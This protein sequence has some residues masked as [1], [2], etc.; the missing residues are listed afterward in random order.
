VTD[1]LRKLKHIKAPAEL[2]ERLADAYQK[3]RTTLEGRWRD[4]AQSVE[5]LLKNRARVLGRDPDEVPTPERLVRKL[6][7]ARAKTAKSKKPP[8]GN[9]PTK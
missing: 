5:L 9:D 8:P 3:Y 2:L 1:C 7:V 4:R 6:K